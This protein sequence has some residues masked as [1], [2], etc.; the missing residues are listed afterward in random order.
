MSVFEDQM[1]DFIY[2][3]LELRKKI[4]RHEGTVWKE[5][6]SIHDLDIGIDYRLDLGVM[7]IGSE[8]Y[9]KNV[10]IR[11]ATKDYG[12]PRAVRVKF[13]SNDQYTIEVGQQVNSPKWT[14][15]LGPGGRSPILSVYFRVISDPDNADIYRIARVG[16]YAE[17]VAEGHAWRDLDWKL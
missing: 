3:N 16:I 13:Y 5:V 11:C 15:V 8:T 12:D 14:E 17:I 1:D 6:S 10:N 4:W 7:N 2:K 9:V